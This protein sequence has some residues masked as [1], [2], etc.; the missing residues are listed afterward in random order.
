MQ[1]LVPQ[2]RRWLDAGDLSRWQRFRVQESRDVHLASRFMLRN[3]L[4]QRMGCAPQAI[5]FDRGAHGKP[6]VKSPASTWQF[7]LSHCQNCVLLVVSEG[8]ALGADI[9]RGKA[10]IA[11][12][13]LAQRVLSTEELAVYIGLEAPAQEAFFFHAWVLKES[14]VKLMGE[15]I[16]HGLTNLITD[17]YAPSYPEHPGVCAHFLSAPNEFHAALA[18]RA[19]H[20]ADKVIIQQRQVQSLHEVAC[21]A[22]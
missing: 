18:Y 1:W 13:D 15:G 21:A 5:E 20:S 11:L 4:A 9:E 10:R 2:A 7:N 16:W 19:D 3:I 8:L 12:A 14:Y 17:V 6:Y 22:K